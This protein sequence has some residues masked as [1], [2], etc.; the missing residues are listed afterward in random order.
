MG[1]GSLPSAGSTA[2]GRQGKVS[3]LRFPRA[4]NSLAHTTRCDG[5]ST[6]N[7]RHILIAAA[8][9]PSALHGQAPKPEPT[10]TLQ[11]AALNSLLGGLSGGVLNAAE[12]RSFVK[13]FV[14]G[15]AGGAVA[16][17]GKR[18]IAERGAF[19]AWSGRQIAAIGA[20]Q[21][22]NAGAGRGML[23]QIVLPFG[24]ARVYVNRKDTARASVKVDLTATIGILVMAMRPETSFDPAASL[25]NGAVVFRNPWPNDNSAGAMRLGVVRISELDRTMSINP[26]T[27]I[28]TSSV[29]AHELIHVAQYDFVNIAISEPLENL[30]LRGSRAG[31]FIHRFVDF[32]S[33]SYAWTAMNAFLETK[34]RPWE[35]EAVSLAPGY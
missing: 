17:A 6:L 35:R 13:G 30:A 33:A 8:L 29:I 25:S 3:R 11:M 5:R 19:A 22:R 12:R 23:E 2:F 28:A 18:I 24:P 20:S 31:R 16:F 34:S 1:S 27:Q 4:A 10:S 14:K 26:P 7:V 32:S 21:V 9:I 15:S